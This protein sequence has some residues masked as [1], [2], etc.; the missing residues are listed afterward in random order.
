VLDIATLNSSI[1][2]LA[3][4]VGVVTSVMVREREDDD[5]FGHGP[6][7]CLLAD[8]VRDA[9]FEWDHGLSPAGTGNI[10]CFCLSASLASGSTTSTRA[11]SAATVCSSDLSSVD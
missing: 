9:S 6:I 5:V 11:E 1:K 4:I 10:L 8:C 7:D 3:N 2:R